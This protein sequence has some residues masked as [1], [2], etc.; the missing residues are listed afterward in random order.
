M[1]DVAD[2]VKSKKKD[3]VEKDISDEPVKSEPPA[4]EKSTGIVSVLIIVY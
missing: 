2:E 4:K 3:S 1:N